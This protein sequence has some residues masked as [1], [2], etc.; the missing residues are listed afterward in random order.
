MTDP[1]LVEWRRSFPTHALLALG[2]YAAIAGLGLGVVWLLFGGEPKSLDTGLSN[3]LAVVMPASLVLAGLGALPYVIAVLRRPVLAA[4]HY[5]LHVRPTWVRTLVLPWARIAKI[6][7]FQVGDEPYLLIRCRSTFDRSGDQPSRIDQSA[8]RAALQSSDSELLDGYDLAVRM[9][10]FTGTP[11]AQLAALAAV[12]PD[13]VAL[14]KE[15]C[16]L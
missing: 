8:L 13:H 16:K 3:P 6:V 1:E 15:V 7:A 10:D 9:R 2:R 5:A 4:N 11:E 14:E 12:T